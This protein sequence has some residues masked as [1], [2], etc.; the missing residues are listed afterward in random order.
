MAERDQVGGPLRGHDPGDLRRGERVALRQRRAALA[1]VSGRHPQEGTRRRR[2]GARAACRPRRPCAR[3]PVSSTWLSASFPGISDGESS[4]RPS[5]AA[6]RSAELRR[7]SRR[8]CRARGRVAGSPRCA[9]A[10]PPAA[11]VERLV[12]RLGLPGDV[13]RV[14]GERP[15]PRAPRARRCSPRGRARRRARS[16]AAPP[17]RRGSCRRRS[18]SRAGRRT[19]CRRRPARRKLSS[20]RRSSGSQPSRW[21]RSFAAA[22]GALDRAHVLRVLGDVLAGRVEEREHPDPPVHL[23]MGVEVELER[24]EA[25][26]DVLRRVGAVDAEDQVLGPRLPRCRP[27]R[28]ARASLVA[29]SSNSAGSTEIGRTRTRTHTVR[30]YGPRRA[31]EVDLGP[32]HVLAAAEE[33]PRPA[34]GVEADDVVREQALVDRAADRLGQHAPVVGLRPRD[35]DEVGDA[36][37]RA[38]RSRTKRRRRVEVVVVE[39]H[40]RRRARA[41]APTSTTSANSRLTAS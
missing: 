34:L 9:R 35:V 36:S 14:D 6:S 10:A 2:A 19:A 3:S 37:P 26:H 18:R 23:R 17:S 39:E 13:E 27:L 15:L 7:R 12:D 5:R 38:L 11:I 1:A 30:R 33:V 4:A 25:A 8:R 20:I 22:G 21:K 16:R 32:D 29:S 40:G 31:R 24:P 41:R 28:R